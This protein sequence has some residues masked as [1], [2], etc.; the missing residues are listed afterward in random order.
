MD[1]WNLMVARAYLPAAFAL[2]VALVASVMLVRFQQSPLL[3]GLALGF[4]W[5]PWLAFVAALGLGTWATVR[6]WRA[7]FGLGM[8]CAC[9]GLLGHERNGRYGAY[10]KCMG[11]S[12]NIAQR[13]YE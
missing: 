3:T 9:G 1:R 13:H 7:E 6:L 10:R 8:L 11:C 12:K 5:V 4:R 2:V